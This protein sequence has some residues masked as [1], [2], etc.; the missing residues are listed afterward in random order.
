[1]QFTQPT[2]GIFIPDNSPA[3]GA[4]ARVTHLG[5]GA[6]PDDL[7]FMAFH[8][9]IECFHSS[10]LHFGGVTCSDGAGSSRTGAYRDFTD[11]QM[12][13]VRRE[14]QRQAAI[15]GRYAAMIQLDHPTSAV[16]SPT[17]AGLRED[18]T[19]ILSHCRPRIVYTHNLADK[20]DTHLGVTVALIEAIRSF[21]P[22]SRP[23]A[24]HG[25]EVWRNLDWLNDGEK[26]AHN[27][28]GFENLAAALNGIF[29]SQIAGG[30]RYDLA[31]MGR[32]RANATFFD[33]HASDDA[34]GLA[35]AM[36]LTPLIKDGTLDILDWTLSHIERFAADVRSRLSRR[37]GR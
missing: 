21:P 23:A 32:R 1:V 2:A 12:K 19:M 18:L 6:H 8:G 15:V 13:S 24:V 14:E 27:V 29:D 11:E 26:V 9:I 35:F 28:S 10:T 20:H 36:D 25:C 31:V 4:L 3:P 34:S 7:E 33:A 37:L 30:K 22:E 5:V 17:D 16:K